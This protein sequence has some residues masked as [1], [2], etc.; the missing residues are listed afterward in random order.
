MT[1]SPQEQTGDLDIIA[2]RYR[3][4]TE[5][6]VP[7]E[8]TWRDCYANA[9]PQRESTVGASTPGG[10]KTATLYDGTAPDAVEQLAA[11]L[12]AE[13]TPPWSRWFALAPGREVQDVEDQDRE[14]IADSL[15]DA[16]ERIRDHFERSNFAVEIHQAYLDLV[17]VGTACLLFEETPLGDVS[18]FQ[19]S[20]VPLGQAAFEEG[21]DGVMVA[22]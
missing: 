6:R 14:D 12:L 16:S 19:F 21:A 17:T 5:R 15:E 20:A 1:R 11:S 18:A 22:G 7:W 4:A 3:K 13:L 10:I 8:A 9:L 2:A